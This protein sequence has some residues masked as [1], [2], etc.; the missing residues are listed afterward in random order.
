MRPFYEAWFRRD[1]SEMGTLDPDIELHA[2]PQN[3]WVGLNAVYRGREGVGEYIRTTL[4]RPS[5]TTT[6]RSR[7]SSMP[8]NRW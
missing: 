2:D 4:K 5:R 1:W 3:E 6:P 8:G 7:G